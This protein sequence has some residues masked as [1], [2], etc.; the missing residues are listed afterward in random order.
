MLCLKEPHTYDIL[1]IFAHELSTLLTVMDCIVSEVKKDLPTLVNAYELAH[2]AGLGVP[3]IPPL[4]LE[5]LTTGL[6]LAENAACNAKSQ[7]S[8][9]MLNM[10]QIDR[11]TITLS[12]CSIYECID[13][14]IRQFPYS[15]DKQRS[16]LSTILDKTMDFMV[17]GNKKLL[18]NLFLNLFYYVVYSLRSTEFKKVSFEYTKNTVLSVLYLK[19]TPCIISPEEL[20]SL[21]DL[22]YGIK[23]HHIG[24]RMVF[25]KNLMEA[26]NGS[27]ACDLTHG[28]CLEITLSFPNPH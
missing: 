25:N 3:D 1:K 19:T 2:Q 4:R 17:M 13:M 27:I 10:T 22:E 24:T 5:M 20:S 14:A 6:N 28:N 7:L 11:D 18:V 16:V 15:S 12:R 9:F 8:S 23:K 21:F 26:L